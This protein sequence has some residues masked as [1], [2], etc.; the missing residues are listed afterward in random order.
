MLVLGNMGNGLCS[1][2]LIVSDS[3]NLQDTIESL[4]VMLKTKLV[5]SV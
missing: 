2:M 5:D 4:D 1:E 3:V